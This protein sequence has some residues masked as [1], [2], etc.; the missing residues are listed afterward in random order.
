MKKV[1]LFLVGLFLVGIYGCGS[2]PPTFLQP[3]YENNAV[4]TIGILELKDNSI[5]TDSFEISDEQL[6]LVESMVI[7]EALN[8]DYDVAAPLE[9]KSFGIDS[10]NDLTREMITSICEKEKVDAILFSTLYKYEDSF[11]GQHSLQMNFNLF[12]ANGDSVWVDKVDL[13]RNGLVG[14]IGLLVGVTV[15]GAVQSNE[16]TPAS[17]MIPVG[18]GV[19]VLA[20]LILEGATNYISA[21]ITERFRNLPEGIGEGNRIK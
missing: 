17:V 3:D 19:G 15:S 10:E 12:K 6:K 21:A 20:G 4:K 13:D 5:S 8:R 9:Y 1:E 16:M 11:L 7:E 14:F 2:V 18:L